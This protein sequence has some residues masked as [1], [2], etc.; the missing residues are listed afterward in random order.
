MGLSAA[1]HVDLFGATKSAA[2]V[3]DTVK[4]SVIVRERERRGEKGDGTERER[5]TKRKREEEGKREV[6][7]VRA[8]YKLRRS[9]ETTKGG[10]EVEQA[11]DDM[12]Y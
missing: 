5:A 10:Q 9:W 2:W 3:K 4:K 1:S 7:C 8:S 12:Y 11:A 6:T